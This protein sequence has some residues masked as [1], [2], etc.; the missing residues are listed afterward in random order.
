MKNWKIN[1]LVFIAAG[2]A[3]LGSF[4]VTRYLMPYLQGAPGIDYIFIPSG[5]RMIAIMAGGIWAALGVAA[6]SLFLVGSEFQLTNPLI[7]LTLAAGTGLFP[8]AA[9][10]A[11]LWALGV[12]SRLTQ[13]TP[14]KLPFISLGVAIGSAALH[15]LQYCA[16]GTQPWS[17][18]FAN[19][20][21]MATGDFTGT[22]IAVVIVFVVLRFL[23]KNSAA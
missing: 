6:G 14:A 22:L 1:G 9:L 21:A 11:S 19:V 5:V 20:A 10:R 13:L 23:R 7:K 17:S 8:Y 16:V 4:T 15:N 3:W 12:D 2:L 18:F